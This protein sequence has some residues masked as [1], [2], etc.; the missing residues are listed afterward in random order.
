MPSTPPPEKKENKFKFQS[1]PG[2]TL[3]IS[4]P[5]PPVSSNDIV[6]ASNA[7]G[8]FNE[9]VGT[10]SLVG[11]EE[12]EGE[13]SEAEPGYATVQAVTGKGAGEGALKDRP[14]LATP[15]HSCVE[16]NG[17]PREFCDADVEL[18]SPL[19][20]DDTVHRERICSGSKSPI[21]ARPR[22]ATGRNDENARDD[23]QLPPFRYEN[24]DEQEGVGIEERS[25]MAVN[26][27]GDHQ[28]QRDHQRR[29][30]MYSKVVKPKKQGESRKMTTEDGSHFGAN[31][32]PKAPESSSPMNKR[33]KEKSKSPL[34]STHGQMMRPRDSSS[35][36]QQSRSSR[37]D[38]Q[39]RILNDSDH[40][41]WTDSGAGY[42]YLEKQSPDARPRGA[43][44]E[45]T[46]RSKKIIRHRR[47]TYDGY[48]YY[49][50][51][52]PRKKEPPHYD[53][54]IDLPLEYTDQSYL[55]SGEEEEDETDTITDSYFNYSGEI[56]GDYPDGSH[57]TPNRMQHQCRQRRHHQEQNH[58]RSRSASFPSHRSSQPHPSSQRTAP[59][60]PHTHS[61]G[62]GH[63]P[64]RKRRRR[65]AT[66]EGIPL[67]QRHSANIPFYHPPS[68]QPVYP[69]SPDQVYVFSEFQPD[70]KVQYYSATPVHS[71]PAHGHTLSPAPPTINVAPPPSFTLPPSNQN[72]PPPQVTQSGYPRLSQS[73]SPQN[74]LTPSPHQVPNGGRGDEINHGGP[75]SS[76]LSD[77]TAAKFSRKV[78]T[79]VTESGYFSGPLGS[80]Q[81]G[82]IHQTQRE[83]SMN[84]S[85]SG[86]SPTSHS[87][88]PREVPQLQL[89][90]TNLGRQSPRTKDKVRPQPPPPYHLHYRQIH[91]HLEH[92]HVVSA[93][94]GGRSKSPG[95]GA[96][97]TRKLLESSLQIASMSPRSDFVSPTAKLPHSNKSPRLD[98]HVSGS[99]ER[100]TDT[101]TAAA[102]RLSPGNVGMAALYEQKEKI[103]KARIRALEES[104][105]DL[106]TEN[107]SLKQ[108]CEALK[109]DASKTHIIIM[110]NVLMN[111]IMY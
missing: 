75:P 2:K 37:Y 90:P 107:A 7:P 52:L 87:P 97:P 3:D 65:P 93:T 21:E 91:Q 16:Q 11:H 10:Y 79:A 84:T 103:L 109:Q 35:P 17:N 73:L 89:Q 5:I 80:S 25:V 96:S 32:P 4:L 33:V 106:C 98:L 94:A 62:H 26:G 82:T 88:L 20:E 101:T 66:S 85:G 19:Q 105:D 23:S 111:K 108:T 42:D 64:P 78:P 44:T 40:R 53:D 46:E 110:Y 56:P 55:P 12:G 43:E 29:E 22:S 24:E 27:R 41:R 102:D 68:L 86:V 1:S 95:S 60:Y 77:K 99:G 59:P 69:I 51:L 70:G 74:M 39:S 71:P 14:R 30:D 8:Q 18:T 58:N 31:L 61:Y 76:S 50:R 83:S 38:Q 34:D 13:E 15:K 67:Q 28:Q 81:Q 92:Q 72:P 45:R 57:T 48:S 47:N 54:D 100:A 63:S 6:T 36:R 9:S 49:D 104:A